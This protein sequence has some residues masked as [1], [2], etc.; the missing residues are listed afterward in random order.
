MKLSSLL[1]LP[2]LALAA[3]TIDSRQAPQI[4]ISSFIITGS[5]C[6]G[7]STSAEIS[8][9]GTS[10]TFGLDSYQ[11]APGSTQ[12]CSITLGLNFPSG[13]T[14]AVIAS[15]YHG[16]VQI[17]SGDSGLF[18]ST[19]SVS[20]GSTSGNPPSTSFTSSQWGNGGVYTKSDSVTARATISN[21]NG[22]VVN[23][24]IGTQ[25]RLTGNP[26]DTSLLSVDDASI[27]ITQVSRC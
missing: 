4:Q 10:I 24:A 18:S 2:A 6:P 8:P 27:S 16:F 23:L 11:V 5:G 14:S 7:G 26:A 15:T 19:Y 1:L 21:S 9:D 22:Q 20:P 17:N 13:C 3:P 12:S 25:I